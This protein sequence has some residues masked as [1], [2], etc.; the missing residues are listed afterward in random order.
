MD[1]FHKEPRFAG[2]FSNKEKKMAK[3]IRFEVENVKRVKVVSVECDGSLVVMGGDNRQGK[4]SVLDAIKWALLGKSY[5]PS[6]L[7]REGALDDPQVKV[8]L[9]NGLTVERY[10]E[11]GSLK[12]TA[13]DGAV[14]R[15]EGDLKAIINLLS[16]DL[17]KFLNSSNR[18]KADALLSIIGCRGELEKLDIR[19]KSLEDE[20]L[21][22]GRDKRTKEA[23]AAELPWH[24]DVPTETQSYAEL[25]D[26]LQRIF[27]VNHEHKQWRDKHQEKIQQWQAL[28]SEREQLLQ[29]VTVINAELNELDTLLNQG[30]VFLSSLKDLDP[31]PT[32]ARIASLEEVIAKVRDY[33]AKLSAKT[34][35]ERLGEKY[36][37]LDNQIQEVRAARLKLLES[38]NLPL[39]ELSILNGELVYRGQKWDCMSGAEQL[40][41]ATSI[42]RQQNSDCG[43]VLIDG[44]ES[45]DI[46][47]LNHYAEWLEAQGMQAIATRVSNG[48]ECSIIIE[49]GMVKGV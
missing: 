12:I 11:N 43:F 13:P 40:M 20:R 7:K 36:T 31:A 45:M 23:H 26:E 24:N 27:K 49:D 42:V 39:P 2:V 28:T 8:T 46:P 21:L 25:R 33:Q 10:G 15:K 41:V 47:T 34:E 44:I 35:A 22:I 3:I 38:A 9:S 29:R 5:A 18:E 17:G 4:S 30:Q 14:S 1:Q 32:E 48:S 16:L 6:G 37:G 19:E